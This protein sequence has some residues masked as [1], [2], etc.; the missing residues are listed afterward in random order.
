MQVHD[1]TS[2]G[3][4]VGP[5]ASLGDLS[6][7]ASGP[8]FSMVSGEKFDA[9]KAYK[10]SKLCNVLFARELSGRLKA[11]GSK[12]T[13]NA[14][15]PGASSTLLSTCCCPAHDGCAWRQWLLTM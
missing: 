12:I 1:P 7:L 3:G 4:Q 9:D 15:G 2:P 6:G 5:G 14:Y 8:N 13:V 11:S 10:D